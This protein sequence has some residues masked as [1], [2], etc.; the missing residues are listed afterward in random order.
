MNRKAAVLLLVGA[1]LCGV[2]GC[3]KKMLPPSP[4]RFTPN[5]EEIVTRN[6][7]RLELRF[8]ED[9]DPTRI[10][11]DSFTIQGPEG[12][13][14]TVRV[15]TA[16]RRTGTVEL[17][18][19]PQEPVLY[20]ITGTVADRAGNIR[21]FNS[22]FRGSARMDTIAPRVLK[23]TPEPGSAG[24][25]RPIV[26]IDFNEPVDTAPGLS[27]LFVPA[28][29]DSFFHTR[30]EPD[31]QT[32]IWQLGERGEGGKDSTLGGRDSVADVRAILSGVIYFALLPGVTDLE[33]NRSEEPVF[34][35]FTAD[36]ALSALPVRGRVVSSTSWQVALVFFYSPISPGLAVVRADGSFSTVLAAGKYRVWAAADENGDNQAELVSPTTEFATEQESLNLHLQYS[37]TR[38]PL[39]A[40]RQP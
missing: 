22:R 16:G 27:F 20:R 26:R 11:A 17:W 13:S 7:V 23:I 21:R 3:A 24:R 34:T 1:I 33:G 18:T 40:Y 32:V 19:E 25:R 6:R 37:E 39:A 35:Y 10:S 15:A 4:D 8:D 9:L 31:G 2:G 12:R 28:A 5:L 30:W 36:S 14:L 29:A 38:K